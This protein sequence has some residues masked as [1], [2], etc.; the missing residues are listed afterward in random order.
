MPSIHLEKLY[1]ENWNKV[2]NLVISG[3]PS[4]HGLKNVR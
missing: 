2:L 4:I 3:M 1:K